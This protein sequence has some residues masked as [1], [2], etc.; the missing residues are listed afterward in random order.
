MH[1]CKGHGGK[2]GLQQIFNENI[3]HQQP[4]PWTLTAAISGAHTVGSAHPDTSGWS[5]AWVSEASAGTFDNSY[6]WHALMFGWKVE[7]D[8]TPGKHQ[9][10]RSDLGL[11]LTEGAH[12]EMML[13]TDLCLLYTYNTDT[14][15][16]DQAIGEYDRMVSF[17][18]HGKKREKIGPYPQSNDECRSNTVNQK[19]QHFLASNAVTGNRC[20]AWTKSTGLQGFQIINKTH[21]H[22]YCGTDH[23]T[24]ITDLQHGGG[25]HEC[26][27]HEPAGLQSGGKWDCDHRYH[28]EGP[29]ATDIMDFARDES[30]WL[31][32]WLEAWH[33][34][35]ENGH[36]SLAFLSSGGSSRHALSEEMLIACDDDT[37]EAT[38]EEHCMRNK[39]I[40]ANL[41]DL[42]DR[43][44]ARL[45]WVSKHWLS[46]EI[47]RVLSG[48]HVR[49]DS[50]LDSWDCTPYNFSTIIFKN[51][52]TLSDPLD[53]GEGPELSPAT[54]GDF[55]ADR[56]LGRQRMWNAELVRHGEKVPAGKA[57][58]SHAFFEDLMSAPS[59]PSRTQLPP[60]SCTVSNVDETTISEW[61][62]P[63]KNGAAGVMR[64]IVMGM[65]DP[66][67]TQWNRQ[68]KF[69]WR[70]AIEGA[71][72]L[73][74]NGTEERM[75]Q[76]IREEHHEI[77]RKNR[78]GV[79]MH[80]WKSY[81]YGIDCNATVDVGRVLR[82]ERR[83]ADAAE[84]GAQPVWGD[85]IVIRKKGTLALCD[86]I[87]FSGPLL[88]AL[89][90]LDD[91]LAALN[92]PPATPIETTATPGAASTSPP[93]QQ[94]DTEA[95]SG[96]G[97]LQGGPCPDDAGEG[98]EEAD[99]A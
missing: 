38:Q 94:M 22:G 91:S 86:V 81:R 4:D 26:C 32:K 23:S 70:D 84:E 3:W 51:T 2:D 37:D 85:R 1:G 65:A 16:C 46:S 42:E 92:G 48:C 39:V 98:V 24:H 11:N 31:R 33:V 59:D 43:G 36:E 14:N 67:G 93:N 96:L 54:Y 52:V 13:D 10:M 87:V 7:L 62:A 83:T 35:T 63:F 20:C 73:I 80:E 5:G 61:S 89:P 88:T 44:L 6:Y 47:L 60:S 71:E 34:A 55:T 29:A 58:G 74:K 99:G 40:A 72:I 64:I 76:T 41:M 56:V 79:K 66:N 53:G 19:D 75:C 68:D 77:I 18:K 27:A 69:L 45:P 90:S 78:A 57:F 21:M 95:P 9:W 17:G 12:K 49:Q 50:L 97:C 28:P 8:V 30:V 25:R 15:Q 82:P